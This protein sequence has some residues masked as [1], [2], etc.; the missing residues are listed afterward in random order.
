MLAREQID[1]RWQEVTGAIHYEVQVVT[2]EGDVLWQHR[3]GQAEAR[4]PETV[5]IAAGQEVYVWVRARLLDGKTLKSE[6]VRFRLAA[7]P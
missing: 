6:P 4:L 3:T 7:T 2:A 1:F 5:V